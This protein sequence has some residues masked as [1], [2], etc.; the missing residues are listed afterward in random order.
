MRIKGKLTSLRLLVPFL[1][2]AVAQIFA[3]AA[4]SGRAPE[5]VSVN[6]TRPQADVV[7][8]SDRTLVM[9]SIEGTTNQRVKSPG[10][11][12]GSFPAEAAKLPL[13]GGC[14]KPECAQPPPGCFYGPPDR[15]QN[16]CPINCGPLVCGPEQ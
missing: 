6:T 3:Q 8:I 2:L 7:L 15:D 4:A 14:V 1:L 5:P 9:K 10:C 13:I 12:S 11:S 16:G